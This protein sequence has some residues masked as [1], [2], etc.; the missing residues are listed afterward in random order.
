MAYTFKHGDRP[1]EGIT[2]QRAVGRGGFGEVYYALADSGKQV[3]LKYLRE[4]PEIELRGI[5]Q[6]MNLKSPHLIT[7]YDVRRNEANEPFVVMEY[8]GGPSLRELMLAEPRGLGVGK[9]AF[10]LKGICRGLSYLHER[11]IVHRDLKP[12]NIF[13]DDGYVKIGDYG[14]SKHMS[15]SKHSGQ[16]VSVGTVH[17]MAP[18]IGSG[19]YTQAIDVYALGVILYEMLTGQLPYTGASMAEVLMRHLRDEPDLTGVPAEFV[20][21]IQKALAKDP[22]DRYQSADEMLAAV[23]DSAEVSAS[24]DAFDATSLSQV[25]RVPEA[26]DPD[27]T[28]TARPPVPPPPPPMDARAIAEREIPERLKRKLDRFSRKM[29]QKA[30]TLERRFGLGVEK[31]HKKRAERHDVPGVTRG[32]WFWHTV[33]LGAIT[34]A[35]ALVLSRF[36]SPRDVEDRFGFLMLLIGGAVIG[37]LFTHLRLLRSVLARNAMFDRLAYASVAGAFVF[38]AFMVGSEIGD[39]KLPP[40]VFGPL[41]AIL[42]CDWS[43]RIE[44]GRAGTVSGGEAFWPAVIGFATALFVDAE[45]YV[46]LSAGV[47][48]AVSLLTQSAAAMWPHRR[49]DDTTPDILGAQHGGVAGPV[50]EVAEGDRAKRSGNAPPLPDTRPAVDD[51]VAHTSL[52]SLPMDPVSVAQPSF[53][54]RTAAAGWAFVGKLL[55][56]VGLL[57]AIAQAP[58]LSQARSAMEGK[59]VPADPVV[60]PLL[61]QGL[62]PAVTVLILV[63]GSLMLLV[64]RRRDGGGHFFRGCVG[65]AMIVISAICLMVYASDALTAMLTARDWSNLDPHTRYRIGDTVIPNLV[66]F[67]I[68]GLLALWPRKPNRETIVV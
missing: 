5:A 45:R 52:P 22:K 46:W 29:E 36:Q 23:M 13:Y 42:I 34:L 56:V 8:V 66:V 63:G 10:F 33:L 20:P 38:P 31:R 28:M 58:L 4:N 15:V 49:K 37:P 1:I 11:G 40:L 39:S 62:P 51:A 6:V 44:S 68:G 17:Y 55:L 65:Y 50:G 48:A 59:N 64:A 35:V 24:V 9:A 12:A 19:S 61:E 32:S 54:G 41:A 2:I 67:A 16:T 14:L 25:P 26:A 3:A 47:C 53:V 30:K 60:R 18:E 21:V 27:Q 43:R 57:L 7:I